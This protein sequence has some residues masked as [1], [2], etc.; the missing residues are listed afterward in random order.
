MSGRSSDKVPLYSFFSHLPHPSQPVGYCTLCNTV[1]HFCVTEQQQWKQKCNVEFGASTTY[2][3]DRYLIDESCGVCLI[4]SCCFF[5]RY[6]RDPTGVL[7][8]LQT[9]SACGASIFTLPTPGPTKRMR[10]KKQQQVT[11]TPGI[12]KKCMID[13]FLFSFF[14]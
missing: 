4:A 6:L 10:K 8:G 12:E 5:F 2:T 11:L 1:I 13:A 7:S 14:L 3:Q 9:L